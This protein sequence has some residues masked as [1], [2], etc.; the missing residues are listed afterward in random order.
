MHKGRVSSRSWTEYQGE[1]RA[2]LVGHLGVKAHIS[3]SGWA[4]LWAAA[5]GRSGHRVNLHKWSPSVT[6]R[7][8]DR[9]QECLGA[10]RVW[11]TSRLSLQLVRAP[12]SC[13]CPLRWS[14]GGIK[15]N[16]THP[17]PVPTS[18]VPGNVNMV[19]TSTSTPK[20]VPA[21]P[22]PFVRCFSSGNHFLLL[23][24]SCSFNYRAFS[25]S[26]GRGIC[27]RSLSDIAPYCRLQW[28]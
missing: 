12:S 23:Q 27:I 14:A 26:Q 20:G 11:E 2:S 15:N 24:Y 4:L 25:V 19:L 9:W 21:I 28:V 1:T 5:D 3:R 16:V 18:N 6:L 10:G 22:L 8:L 17:A 7:M 13:S